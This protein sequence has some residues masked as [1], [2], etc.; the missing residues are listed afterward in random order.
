MM[1]GIVRVMK[2]ENSHLS[3]KQPHFDALPTKYYTFDSQFAANIYMQTP[4]EGG[5]LE[6]WD[7]DALKPG[8]H[9][10]KDWRSKLPPSI[11]IQAKMGDL[12]LFNCR[13]P[14]AIGEFNGS[15]RISLQMFIGFSKGEPLLLWN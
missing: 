13:R 4:E 5:C 6:L 11:Q 1:A 14:H 8:E 15:Q 2:S 7:V 3:A 10:P 12:I 9:T